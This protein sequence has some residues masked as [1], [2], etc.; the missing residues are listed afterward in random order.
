MRLKGMGGPAYSGACV[1]VST[2]T[3]GGGG[4]GVVGGGRRTGDDETGGEAP[5]STR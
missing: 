2:G 3:D 4:D 1:R 5:T